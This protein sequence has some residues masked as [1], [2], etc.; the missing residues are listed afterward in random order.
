MNE[1]Y[2]GCAVALIC[3]WI[4]AAQQI[5]FAVFFFPPNINYLNVYAVLF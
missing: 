4:S 3:V 1:S 5:F 2:G